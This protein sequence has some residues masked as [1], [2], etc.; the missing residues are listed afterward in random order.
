MRFFL[1]AT[2]WMTAATASV[3]V[4]L[5]Q[6]PAPDRVA[7][8]VAP[9]VDEQTVAVVHANLTAFDVAATIDILVRGLKWPEDVRDHLQV[10]FAPIQ[11]VTQGLPETVAVDT[12]LVISI[13][14]LAHLPFFLVVPLDKTT[15][16]KAIAL[17]ARREIG[18]GWRR[19]VISEEIGDTLITGAPATIERLKKAKPVARPEIAAAF[20]AAELGGLQFAIVPSAAMRKLAEGLLPKLPERLGG[21]PTKSFTQG[22]VWAAVGLDLPPKAIAVRVVLQS[23]NAETATALEAEIRKLF[24]ALGEF[25][26]FKEAVP[27]YDELSKRL[28]PM[29]GGDRLKLELTEANGG[30]DALGAILPTFTRMSSEALSGA[31]REEPKVEK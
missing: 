26:Q 22:I 15:P 23:T 6:E 12:I 14:D 5:A 10:Q 21:G 31:R 20:Q 13:S 11:V 2:C 25:P 16:A 4:L 18:Q 3:G 1:A 9:L 30:I 24:A 8:I 29:A 28:V 17:E 7:K 19:E 27:E